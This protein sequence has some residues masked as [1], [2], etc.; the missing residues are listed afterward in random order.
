MTAPVRI[1]R[2][3][4]KG[5]NLQLESRAT[6]GLECVNVTRPGPYGNPFFKGC[7]IGY[8]FFDEKMQSTQHDVSDPRVQVMWFRQRMADMRRHEPEK[9]EALVSK[10]S[11]KNVACWCKTTDVCHGD[12]WLEL[13]AEAVTA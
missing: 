6:N 10:L 12:V 9:F 1:Q 5:F 7:G 2:K 4:N 3:R 13:A 11:G 8:G